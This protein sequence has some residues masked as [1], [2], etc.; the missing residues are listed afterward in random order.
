[1]Q[2]FILF[3][4]GSR[5]AQRIR[6]VSCK[7]VSNRDTCLTSYESGSNFSANIHYGAECVWKSNETKCEPK[8]SISADKEIINLDQKGF[9]DCLKNSRKSS[10]NL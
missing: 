1:M 5:C 10:V 2:I 4:A 7:D 3:V 8:S 6:F 9:E